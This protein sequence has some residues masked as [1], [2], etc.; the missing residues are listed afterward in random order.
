[1]E[2][3]LDDKLALLVEWD[4]A[5]K[6]LTAAKEHELNLRK[7]VAALYF[8][9]PKEGTNTAELRNDY[10]LKLTYGLSREIADEQLLRESLPELKELGYSE[11]DLVITKTTRTVNAKTFKSLSGRA[12]TV[13]DRCLITKP[14]TPSIS[15]AAPKKDKG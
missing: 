5:K 12:Q 1:M 7:A 15:I 4:K 2:N 10:Q 14:K 8:P 6:A 13:F 9:E 3:L 11:S